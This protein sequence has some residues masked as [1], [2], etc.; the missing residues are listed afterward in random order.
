MAVPGSR[1]EEGHSRGR[2]AGRRLRGWCTPALSGAAAGLFAGTGCHASHP[3]NLGKQAGWHARLPLADIGSEQWS[4]MVLR[5]AAALTVVSDQRVDNFRG[6]E[7][8]L[9]QVALSAQRA[10]IHFS[11]QR[12]RG[13]MIMGSRREAPSTH[14]HGVSFLSFFLSMGSRREG[15]AD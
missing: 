13:G 4:G 8:K 14:A 9:T 3:P 12:C 2:T 7:H 10:G 6:V 5:S 11:A 15:G 1:L